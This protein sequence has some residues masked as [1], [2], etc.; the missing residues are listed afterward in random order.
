MRY[1]RLV[2]FLLGS[3]VSV[4]TSNSNRAAVI[5]GQGTV[6][7]KVASVAPRS[8]RNRD[9]QVTMEFAEPCQSFWPSTT[10]SQARL[11]TITL[12]IESQNG[13]DFEVFSIRLSCKVYFG[14]FSSQHVV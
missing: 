5:S 8:D 6:I 12:V 7:G 13:I 11:F 1:D 14:Y 4:T 3:K 9:Y 10:L 2:T